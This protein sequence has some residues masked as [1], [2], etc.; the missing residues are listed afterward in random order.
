VQ[1]WFRREAGTERVGNDFHFDANHSGIGPVPGP[2]RGAASCD[3]LGGIRTVQ[4][5]TGLQCSEYQH[6]DHRHE[7]DRL[8]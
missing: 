5:H 7:D 6:D 2:S 8:D 3:V 1:R 4:R